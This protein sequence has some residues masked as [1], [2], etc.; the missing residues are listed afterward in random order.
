MYMLYRLCLFTERR[1]GH[2][3]VLCTAILVIAEFTCIALCIDV[4]EVSGAHEVL[5]QRER[6]GLAAY[7]L[8]A[9]VLGGGDA[10]R[11]YAFAIVYAESLFVP[12]VHDRR[13]IYQRTQCRSACQELR[14]ALRAASCV[15][16]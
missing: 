3:Q 5:H 12:F 16:C 6:G 2:A 10:A 7:V 11:V 8:V 1:V 13:R 15:T 4:L 9:E 14:R